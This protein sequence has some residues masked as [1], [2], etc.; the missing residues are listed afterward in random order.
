MGKNFDE[1]Q[2]GDSIY[3]IQIVGSKIP[4]GE[5]IKEHK[6][7]YVN[8]PLQGLSVFISLDNTRVITPG[9]LFDFYTV[10]TKPSSDLKRS[11]GSLISVMEDVYATSREE[12]LR[13]AA[14]TL[15]IRMGKIHKLINQCNTELE[16]LSDSIVQLKEISNSLP[17][18]V[19]S[20]TVIV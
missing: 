1:I 6:V 14:N 12:C 16:V 4:E 8:K 19:V 15:K 5:N 17:V 2:V 3:H 11:D 10:G 18:E 9:R 7:K 13:I 20:E